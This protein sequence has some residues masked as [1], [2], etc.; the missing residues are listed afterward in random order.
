VS[1]PIVWYPGRISCLHCFKRSLP[2]DELRAFV[3]LLRFFELFEWTRSGEG[4]R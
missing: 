4:G 2:R 3:A 1:D